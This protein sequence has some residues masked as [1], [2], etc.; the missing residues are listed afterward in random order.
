MTSNFAAETRE[1][2]EY[3]EVYF[4]FQDMMKALIKDQ[5]A[6]PLKY[7]VDWLGKTDPMYLSV[8][9]PPSC[10]RSGICGELAAAFN[11]RHI[12]VGALLEK[13]AG[14]GVLVNDDV[15]IGVVK[16]ALAEGNQG[17]NGY[18][19]DGFPRTKVQARA[20]QNMK[21]V[22]QRLVVLQPDMEKIR[23][24]MLNDAAKVSKNADKQ[25][26]LVESRMQ[27]YFRHI[28]TTQEVFKNI[29]LEV[30]CDDESTVLTQVQSALHQR[31]HGDPR[32]PLRV[33]VVGPLG[34][35]RTTQAKLLATDFG[36]VHVDAHAFCPA[37]TPLECMN[38]E[39]LC[40][41]VGD[42]LRQTD[43]V[44]K[45]WVLDG[46]PNTTQQAEFLKKAHLWPSRV[47]HLSISESVCLQRL[48]TRK[49]DPLTNVMYY[50]NPPSNEIRARL[51]R[52]A[53]DE[54]NAVSERYHWHYDRHKGLLDTFK[55][56]H[57]ILRA[58]QD[59]EILQGAIQ[60]YVKLPLRD[61]GEAGN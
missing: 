14:D 57:T 11:C 35:G 44:R 10:N 6:E 39:D 40:K 38:D 32:G 3:H 48:S 52:A 33:S 59:P 49:V 17:K 16:K 1:Y 50:G 24:K 47:V 13:S 27:N 18:I 51:E 23:K 12:H 41:A 55:N 61:A 26:D 30:P 28:N 31:L 42:R 4:L 9:S 20:L 56:N 25:H 5:P 37:G 43:C 53:N 2:L 7:L 60:Q 19:L 8:L 45:G 58:N 21:I 34:S 36:V 15:V 46:F 22:P 29:V 54:P